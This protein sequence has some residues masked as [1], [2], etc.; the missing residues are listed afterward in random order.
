MTILVLPVWV[1]V[2]EPLRSLK[3]SSV[4]SKAGLKHVLESV[5]W[6]GWEASSLDREQMIFPWT[7]GNQAPNLQLQSLRTTTSLCWLLDSGF[8]P[9]SMSQEKVRR[10]EDQSPPPLLTDLP[11]GFVLGWFHLLVFFIF[12]LKS[13]VGSHGCLQAVW[14]VQA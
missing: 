2:S 11:G 13:A 9:I 4:T 6:P 5:C 7:L 10:P 8:W 1:P 14:R 12:P 3:G